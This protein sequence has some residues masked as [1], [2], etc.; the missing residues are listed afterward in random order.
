MI[1]F[2]FHKIDLSF[3]VSKEI[4]R[5]LNKNGEILISRLAL[6]IDGKPGKFAPWSK[7]KKSK[8]R[9]WTKQI[10]SKKELIV[11]K[12]PQ[13]GEFRKPKFPCLKDMAL[14]LKSETLGGIM[15]TTARNV[16]CYTHHQYCVA[17]ICELLNEFG[18]EFYLS[19]AELAL[20][21]FARDEHRRYI[22]YTLPRSFRI[23]GRSKDSVFHYDENR[24]RQLGGGHFGRNEYWNSRRDSRQFHMYTHS[25]NDKKVYRVEIILRRPYLKRRGIKEP[26]QIMN[27]DKVRELLAANISK[28]RVQLDEERFKD[29]SKY[30]H[31]QLHLMKDKTAFAQLF[32]LVKKGG[33]TRSE[34]MGYFVP[35][36]DDID[37]YIPDFSSY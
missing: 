5:I 27:K 19:C 13:L 6:R 22:M 32:E 30:A 37:I 14:N 10:K 25:L 18:I 29:S 11:L 9:Y 26:L 15:I 4:A 2:R 12:G 31:V 24:K 23:L 7:H 35:V 28:K 8:R 1:Y 33:M 3:V 21:T 36:S 17:A 16:E 20:D 34:A